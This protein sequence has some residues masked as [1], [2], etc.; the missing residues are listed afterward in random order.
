MV[1]AGVA[2]AASAGGAG[3][4][5]YG[6]NA[7]VTT[8]EVAALCHLEGLL[9]RHPL[10]LSSGE[11]QRLALAKALLVNPSVLLLDEP[12][13]G[14]DALFKA[15]LGALLQRL[16][17]RGLTV[18][19]VSHDVEFCAEWTDRA[20]LLFDGAIVASGAPSQLF[21]ASAFYTTAASRIARGA[22]PGA[23]TVEDVVSACRNL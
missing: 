19:A 12:T 16:A 20:A 21:A 22:V 11:Q 6:G 1:G 2:G 13:K 18:V 17:Q 8:E 7:A 10:D 9:D 4:S 3:D 14:L 23:V 5:A 15:E